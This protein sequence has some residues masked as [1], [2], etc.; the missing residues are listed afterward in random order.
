MTAIRAQYLA[1]ARARARAPTTGA[2][3]LRSEVGRLLTESNTTAGYFRWLL[4]I[5]STSTVAL[6]TST[7]TVARARR[8]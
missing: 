3:W 7:S 1:R 4:S 6:S 2:V 8:C 5:T